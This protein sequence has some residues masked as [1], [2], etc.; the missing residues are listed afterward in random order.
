MS[1][2]AR[3]KK[4]KRFLETIDT[5]KYDV[6]SNDKS[7]KVS[8]Y[9]KLGTP[10]GYLV[11]CSDGEECP[12]EESIAPYRLFITFN[13]FLSGIVN[14]GQLEMNKPTAVFKDTI[15]LLEKVKPNIQHSSDNVDNATSKITELDEGYKNYKT[16]HDSALKIYEDVVAA[17]KLDEKSVERVADLMDKFTLLQ[18][19]NLHLQLKSKEDFMAITQELKDGNGNDSKIIEKAL[20]VFGYLTSEKYINGIHDNLKQFESNEQDVQVSYY[21]QPDWEKKFIESTNQ[22]SD[23]QFQNDALSILR[24]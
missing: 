17:G 6:I 21:D 12:R 14:Q 11:L 18:Y 3:F 2:E 20:D 9:N 19:K 24:N 4:H 5:A 22:R 10:K 15:D 16:L 23:N 7:Y 1:I 8:V 13:A